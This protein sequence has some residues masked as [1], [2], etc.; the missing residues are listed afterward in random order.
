M[1][2]CSSHTDCC[3]RLAP[4][5]YSSPS[6]SS[7]SWLLQILPRPGVAHAPTR[8]QDPLPAHIIKKNPSNDNR[9]PTDAL[10]G[11]NAHPSKLS[12]TTTTSLSSL[13]I[14]RI[15]IPNSSRH[16]CCIH[17]TPTLPT[18]SPLLENSKSFFTH[19]DDIGKT[20]LPASTTLL[21]QMTPEAGSPTISFP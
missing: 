9:H 4:R 15:T 20:Q 6:S 13:T 21:T 10:H 1:E 8:T 7:Y 12:Q 2:T 18:V 17:T 14:R 16:L 19:I 11:A 5:Q 3:E